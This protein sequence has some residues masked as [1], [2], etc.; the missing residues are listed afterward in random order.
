MVDLSDEDELPFPFGKYKGMTANQV[1]EIDPS[2]VVWAYDHW[3]CPPVSKELRDACEQDMR[4]KE[5]EASKEHRVFDVFDF[6]Q[7]RLSRR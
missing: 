3:G 7:D 2:Y 5:K 4:E 6:M 1:A